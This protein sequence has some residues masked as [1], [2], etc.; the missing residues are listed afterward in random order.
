MKK[1]VTELLSLLFGMPDS[2]RN[3][4][5]AQELL[6]RKGSRPCLVLV[7]EQFSVTMER[8]LL[9]RLGDPLSLWV[10]VL[11]FRRLPDYVFDRLGGRAVQ[12]LSEGGMRILLSGALAPLRES[13]RYFGQASLKSDF[14][15]LL[16]NQFREF[17]AYETDPDELFALANALPS[18][19]LSDKLFDLALLY[20]GLLAQ[21]QGRRSAEFALDAAAELLRQDNLFAS[22][23]LFLWNFKG[24]TPQEYEVLEIMLASG[25]SV[26]VALLGE[27]VQNKEDSP[28]FP[29]LETAEHLRRLAAQVGCGEAP[30]RWLPPAGIRNG[31]LAHL[32]R[33]A[34]R[35]AAPEW[36]GEPDSL[37]EVCAASQEEEAEFVAS[38]ILSLVRT[39]SRW[40]EI[41]VILRQPPADM[42][43]EMTFRRFG[44]PVQI[45]NRGSLMD[46]P[47]CGLLFAAIQAVTGGFVCDD[48]LAY[49][50]TGLAGLTLE[51]CDFLE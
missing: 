16:R 40:N 15:E 48:V 37:I 41:A 43:L 1:G 36:E 49:L 4:V 5:L 18:Q 21:M 24:F 17:A 6:K 27:D 20:Q 46:K 39:G 33:Y 42:V 29:C 31:T 23:D 22:T 51:E 14:I 34:F 47:L 45:D 26:T 28:L 12:M 10:E 25:S 50:K 35:Q 13:L 2:D 19:T 9:E 38:R 8:Q 11:S 3:E 32:E 7:P 30:E 44:I